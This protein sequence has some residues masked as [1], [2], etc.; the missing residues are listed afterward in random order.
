MPQYE[1]ELSKTEQVKQ[2]TIYSISGTGY[3]KH[4]NCI[5]NVPIPQMLQ[6]EN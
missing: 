1:R 2:K 3:M 6:G 5:T 4:V